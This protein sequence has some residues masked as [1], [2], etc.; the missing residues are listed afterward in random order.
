[1]IVSTLKSVLKNVI[2]DPA[3]YSMSWHDVLNA[4]L[5][6]DKY[7]LSLY[8]LLLKSSCPLGKSTSVYRINHGSPLR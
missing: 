1:M 4:S 3:E 6:C 7:A 5:V 2:L 8:E